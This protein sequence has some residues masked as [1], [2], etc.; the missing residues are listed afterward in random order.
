LKAG[1]QL[2]A[3]FDRE[4]PKSSLEGQLELPVSKCT[5]SK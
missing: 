2:R 3:M 4:L 1:K 5:C